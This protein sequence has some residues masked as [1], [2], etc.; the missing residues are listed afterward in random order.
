MS[1]VTV[2]PVDEDSSGLADLAL[3]AKM[4]RYVRE[5]LARGDIQQTIADDLGVDRAMVSKYKSGAQVGSLRPATTRRL[6]R[7]TG[8]GADLEAV[9]IREFVAE[10]ELPPEYREAR[11]ILAGRHG[12][13]FT[14]AAVTHLA[15]HANEGAE[16]MDVYL[17]AD[18]IYEIAQS[19]KG[20]S[21]PNRS[22]DLEDTAELG[23]AAVRTKKKGGGK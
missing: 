6:A 4:R 13:D 11:G 20:K 1:A 16:K 18:Q 7:L 3:V 14:F 17:L 23:A 22:A 10:P 8:L 2:C 15:M 21:V 9:A 12:R 19:E 5:R